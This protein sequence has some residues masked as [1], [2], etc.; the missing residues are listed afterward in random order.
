MIKYISLLLIFTIVVIPNVDAIPLSDKTGLKFTFPVKTDDRSFILDATGNFDIEHLD[1]NKNEK[2][3]TLFINSSINTNLL[4]ISIPKS[5]IGG[6]FKFF[7][8]DVQVFPKFSQGKNSIFVTIE[9]SGVGK[10]VVKLQGTTYLDVYDVSEEI[11]YKI[12]NAQITSIESNPSTNSLVFLITNSTNGKL[13]IN[14]YD[15]V[16]KP[17]ENN[18]FIILIDGI[19]SDYSVIDQILNVNFNSDA[20]KITII[21]T[22]VI[23]EFYEITPLILAT[24][25]IGLIILKKY[26]KLFV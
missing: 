1:F 8:D 5:L 25:F 23:P 26:K 4:E 14:L 24:S 20:N 6:D 21:G 16:I 10:H 9:F 11:D 19:E 12:T 22:Y 3:I 2:S 15:D 18:E 17:F 13:S 7:V